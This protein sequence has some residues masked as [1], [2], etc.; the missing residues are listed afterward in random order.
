MTVYNGVECNQDDP[1]LC[2]SIKL[3]FPLLLFLNI[4][5]LYN[6]W[7]P[8][9]DSWIYSNPWIFWQASCQCQEI[10]SASCAITVTKLTLITWERIFTE[11]DFMPP[12]RKEGFK[13]GILNVLKWEVKIVIDDKNTS[14][15]RRK[16]YAL[17]DI[18]IELNFNRGFTWISLIKIFWQKF[19][20]PLILKA[21]LT[22]PVRQAYSGTSHRC[23]YG[24]CECSKILVFSGF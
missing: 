23:D 10:H 4:N 15:L 16:N 12:L 17:V 13:S 21:T 6:G 14:A 20:K 3:N 2:E 9:Y 11:P 19:G 22:Q 24:L 5:K 7:I 18:L 8:S 1:R